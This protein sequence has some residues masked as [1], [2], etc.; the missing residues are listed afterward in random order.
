MWGSLS[1]LQTRFPA[2][3]LKAS[4]CQDCLP[5]KQALFVLILGGAGFIGAHILQRLIAAGH[6]ITVFPRNKSSAAAPEKTEVLYGDRNRLG[7]SIDAFRRL[8]PYVVID[9]IGSPEQRRRLSSQ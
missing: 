8:R 5:P 4:C 3:R 7:D 2:S 9:A 6:E 1:R